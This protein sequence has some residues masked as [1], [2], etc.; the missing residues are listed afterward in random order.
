MPTRNVNLTLHYDKFI[1][2]KIESGQY[3]D[4]NEVLCAGLALLEQK[5]HEEKQKLERL[6]SEIQKGIDDYDTGNY[7]TIQNESEHQS[8]MDQ[9]EL[10]AEAESKNDSSYKV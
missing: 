10:D 6:R 5:E 7:I 1:N 8:L 3:Q 2:S 4:A 9:L